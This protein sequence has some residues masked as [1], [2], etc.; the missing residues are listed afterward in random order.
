MSFVSDCRTLTVTRLPHP[1]HVLDWVFSLSIFIFLCPSPG[2]AQATPSGMCKY[3]LVEDVFIILRVSPHRDFTTRTSI[4]TTTLSPSPL[5]QTA[6]LRACD[7]ADMSTITFALTQTTN[8]VEALEYAHARTSR[9]SA[10][11][12]AHAHRTYFAAMLKN[13]VAD[14]GADTHGVRWQLARAS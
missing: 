6:F 12:D 3:C 9:A 2:V 13:G 10:G 14:T 7:T 1:C 4:T 8:N 5:A 11:H